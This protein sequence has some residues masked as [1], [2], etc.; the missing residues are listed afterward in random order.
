MNDFSKLRVCVLSVCI[1]A[2]LIVGRLV[3][4]VSGLVL[5]VG[6]LVLIVDGLVLTVGGLVLSVIGRLVLI[7]GRLGLII[8]GLYLFDSIR[9]ILEAWLDECLVVV[10]LRSVTDGGF[11]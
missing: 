1:Y 9:R 11:L 7:V 3:L 4:I 10:T 5:I 2:G 6:G 8:D